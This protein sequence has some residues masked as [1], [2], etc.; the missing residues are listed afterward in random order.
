MINSLSIV[1]P[2]F[3]EE[4]RLPKLFREIKKFSIKKK[5]DLEFIFVDDG[6]FDESLILIKEFKKVNLKK[7]NIKIIS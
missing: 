1:F 6:S 7:I 2:L 5:I 3:N 4:N